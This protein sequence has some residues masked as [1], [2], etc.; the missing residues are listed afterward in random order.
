MFNN[1]VCTNILILNEKKRGRQGS[2]K[3]I[4][5]YSRWGILIT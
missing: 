2:F 3:I 5:I 1:P 4:L